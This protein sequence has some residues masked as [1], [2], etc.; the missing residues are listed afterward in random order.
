MA[1]SFHQAY[2]DLVGTLNACERQAET[3]G[4][5]RTNP[6][7][8]V[9][10]HEGRAS[11]DW[12]LGQG[13][14]AHTTMALRAQEDGLRAAVNAFHAT[15]DSSLPR[16]CPLN[17]SMNLFRTAANDHHSFT[18]WRWEFSA[19]ES[20]IILGTLTHVA[21]RLAPVRTG[22]RTFCIQPKKPTEWRVLARS[23]A[24]ALLAWHVLRFPHVPPTL[25][26]LESVKAEIAE[27]HAEGTAAAQAR[28]MHLIAQHPQGNP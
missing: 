22:P 15:L 21:E 23:P 16:L 24:D 14:S 5:D 1:H 13:N 6:A 20:S 7:L 4:V 18:L 19:E 9:R 11:V 27:I 25:V 8:T 3:L 17:W 2:H 10:S 12:N 26:R 28:D